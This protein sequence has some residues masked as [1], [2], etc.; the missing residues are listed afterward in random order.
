MSA[1]ERKAFT[2]VE[3]LVV[4]AIIGVLVALLMPAIQAAREAARRT[5]CTNNMTQLAK[6][7]IIYE[8]GHQF[9]PP[10]RSM[11][12]LN[13]ATKTPMVLN[14]VYPI[15]PSLERDSLHK[16]IRAD[17]F[18][19]D[20]SG[21]VAIRIETL[22]CPSGTPYWS[23]S[24]LS[25]VVN[26]GRAN[27]T[28]S[29]GSGEDRYNFDWIE[30]GVFIDKY[31]DPG[32]PAKE[33]QA[34]LN[35]R[36]A[37]STISKNDGTSMTIMISENSAPLDWRIA[38][39]EQDSQVLWFPEDP[40]TFAGFVALNQKLR[41]N[42]TDFLSDVR[43]ARPSSWHPGGFILAYCDGSVKF[44]GENTDYNLFA[45]LMSSNGKKA[46]NPDDSTPPA[47]V[48]PH[49]AWQSLPITDFL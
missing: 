22:L 38:P 14:W 36:H 34:L 11:G 49:P 42:R 43:Y 48:L 32:W 39:S 10:S 28:G 9:L 18:P 17:G 1:P 35:A 7:V 33:Q 4:I 27:F 16:E 20:A 13:D 19:V 26:G 41:V 3:L 2:I 30:N 45:R 44:M 15:L 24:P 40:T 21:A 37:L 29:T 31:I 8:T 23:N 25:Y 6:A 12:R 5:T 46:R 47:T